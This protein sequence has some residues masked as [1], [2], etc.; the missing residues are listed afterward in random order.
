MFSLVCRNALCC[1]SSLLLHVLFYVY[2]HKDTLM[3]I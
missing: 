1:G 2:V 3:I